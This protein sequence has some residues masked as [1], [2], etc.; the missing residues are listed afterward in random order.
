METDGR[1]SHNHIRAQ[2]TS[3]V[4]E[5]PA[6]LVV[7]TDASY[8]K[9]TRELERR[10]CVECGEQFEVLRRSYERRCFMCR[11]V[12][13]VC[14]HCNGQF[15]VT[16]EELYSN[17][18]IYC[19]LCGGELPGYSRGEVTRFSESSKR[20]LMQELNKVQRDV[21]TVNFVT[22]T[23]PDEFFPRNQQPEE[24][25]HCLREFEWRFRRE[26]P[27]AAYVWRL[28]VEDRK[29]GQHIGE[30]FPHFHLLVFNV[31][32]VDLRPW[33]EKNWH[34]VA[35]C[36]NPE[37]LDVLRREKSVTGVISRRGVMSYAAKAVG[38]VMSR[39][40]AKELQA[41]GE[42]VGRWWGIV[43]KDI[44]KAFQ[45]VAEVFEITD[46]DA[47][48]LMR[49]FRNYIKA[50]VLKKW[51]EEGKRWKKPVSKVFQVRSRVVFLHGSWLKKN[52]PRLL[53]GGGGA[54]RYG[55]TGR[56]YDMPFLQWQAERA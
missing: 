43:A 6:Q 24:W 37:H 41:K 10:S 9:V 33:V 40:L 46:S 17:D 28:E 15:L 50:Q 47:A 4:E 56:R 48:S 20:R 39:E 2:G 51:R 27:N 18:F 31:R 14:L 19:S 22:L 8:G 7:Y 30:F 45:A 38:T 44:F 29:S 34:E 5:I 36:G 52:V 3:Q 49:I 25:K 35:G 12:K 23:F 11:D 21:S 26:F 13:R 32:L 42:N 53:S 1:L 54:W 55:A 16:N